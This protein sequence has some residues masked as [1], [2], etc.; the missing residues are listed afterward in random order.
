MIKTVNYM[1]DHYVDGHIELY[2]HDRTS[3]NRMSNEKC[4]AICAF[5]SDIMRAIEALKDD[6]SLIITLMKEQYG[7]N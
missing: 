2:R 6:E 5:M 4:D 3:A 1:F 7:N